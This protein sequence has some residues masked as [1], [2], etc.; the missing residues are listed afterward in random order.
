MGIPHFETTESGWLPADSDID[1]VL[2][3]GDE[4]ALHAAWNTFHHIRFTREALAKLESGGTEPEA[5]LAAYWR[6]EIASLA[7]VTPLQALQANRRL[8]NLLTGRRWSVMRLAR[9]TG[10]SW[11]TI[12]AA[13]DMTKQGALDW[14]Q[15]KIA[16]QEKYVPEFHDTTRARAV[17]DE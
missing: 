14:Y 15:R 6:D 10:A 13:L 2:R 4:H 7:D 11:S 1:A 12:G 3:G 16:D 9:E 8:V 17:L 5:D